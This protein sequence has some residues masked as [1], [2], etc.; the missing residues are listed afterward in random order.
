VR[1]GGERQQAARLGPPGLDGRLQD[2]RQQLRQVVGR[3]EGLAEAVHGAGQLVA[4][5][6]K[7]A[8]VLAQLDAHALE[9][10][11]ELTDL[12]AGADARRGAGEVAPGDR[13]GLGGQLAEGAADHPGQDG[14]EHGG[15]QADHHQPEAADRAG[16]RGVADNQGEVGVQGPSGQALELLAVHPDA[17][18]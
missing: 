3:G 8:Q 17:R 7:G 2:H 18:P 4:A 14:A 15:D 13:P 12:A 9:G 11:G 16:H 10:P 5:G 1:S 6:P